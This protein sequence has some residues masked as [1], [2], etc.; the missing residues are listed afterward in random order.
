MKPFT[1]AHDAA[2]A[3]YTHA[4]KCSL[5][6]G[7]YILGNP[8]LPKGKRLIEVRAEFKMQCSFGTMELQHCRLSQR[9]HFEQTST[10]PAP[11]DVTLPGRD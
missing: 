3:K 5:S 9:Y 6:Q 2:E 11:M 4:S 10:G 8:R 7:L 1:A